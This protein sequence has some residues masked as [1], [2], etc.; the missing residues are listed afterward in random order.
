MAKLTVLDQSGPELILSAPS[1]FVRSRI[2]RD[3]AD[4]IVRYWQQTN[5][6]ISKLQVIVREKDDGNPL[7]DQHFSGPLHRSSGVLERHVH[8]LLSL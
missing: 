8:E 6:K 5:P 4:D 2:M 7:R 1:A 3:F